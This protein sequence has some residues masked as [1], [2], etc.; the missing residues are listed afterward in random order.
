MQWIISDLM[1]GGPVYVPDF[2]TG[3]KIAVCFISTSGLSVLN[4]DRPKVAQLRH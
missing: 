1:A 2:T 4:V 3:E